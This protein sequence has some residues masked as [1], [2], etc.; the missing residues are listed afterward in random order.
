[1]NVKIGIIIYS[2]TGNTLSVAER[3]KESLL[4]TGHTVSLE[5]VEKEDQSAKN[6]VMLKQAPDISMYDHVIIGSPVQGFSLSPV[7]MA[8]LS[9]LP[10]MSDKKYACFVTQHFPKPW[11]GGRRAINQMVR[12]V[13]QKEGK[14]VTTGVVNWSNQAREEQI[15]KIIAEF[16]AIQ[17]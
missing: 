12:L 2:Q 9:Q 4:N 8:Y 1:M 6:T 5:R 13:G 17:V 16:G 15:S 14:V 3:L 7:M 11:M 10:K